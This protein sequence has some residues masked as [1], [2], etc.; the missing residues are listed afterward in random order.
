MC[1][2]LILIFVTCCLLVRAGPLEYNS[3]SRARDSTIITQPA[4]VMAYIAGGFASSAAQ[5]SAALSTGHTQVAAFFIRPILQP[6]REG[7][8]VYWTPLSCLHAS[9]SNLIKLS[10]HVA[11][12]HDPPMN[13][14]GKLK[15]PI[16]QKLTMVSLVLECTSILDSH[17]AQ[18]LLICKVP[19]LTF[20]PAMDSVPLL[21]PVGPAGSNVSK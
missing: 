9:T 7:L 6:E 16:R 1:I 10:L 2:Y 17:A 14:L 4:V 15:R 13:E 3:A 21:C 8:G 5:T 20:G 18:L 12:T 19:R 11:Q